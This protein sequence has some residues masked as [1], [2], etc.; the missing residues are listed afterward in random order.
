MHGVEAFFCCSAAVT[1][2]IEALPTGHRTLSIAPGGGEDIDSSFGIFMFERFIEKARRTIFFARYE[3][4]NYGS[5]YIETEHLLL[6]L[7]REDRA[8]AKY[9]LDKIGDGDELRAEIDKRITRRERISTSVDVPLTDESKKILYLAIE[10]AERLGSSSIGT[11]HILLGILRMEGSLAAELLQARGVKPTPL[12]EQLAKASGAS[13]LQG[14]ARPK[15]SLGKHALLR[16]DDFLAGLKWHSSEELTLFF[17]TSAQFIDATG[18]RWNRAEISKEFATLFAP[19][20][21]KNASYVV[22]GTLAETSELVIATV[23]WKNAFLASEQRI[24]IHRMTAVLIS[25]G[26]HWF[27]LS[28]QVT[29]VQF[30]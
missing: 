11:E 28:V 1:H 17:A 15:E 26:V 12:S 21:K 30:P 10:E 23:L 3:A 19:Y 22:E 8:L 25:Q 24:W 18:K 14:A 16:L 27:I 4:S 29:P 7:L 13:R 2:W 5:S 9:C 6:G 20:A